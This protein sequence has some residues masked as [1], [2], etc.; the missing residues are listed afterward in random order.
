MVDVDHFKGYNDRYGNLIGDVCLK[1]VAD[2]MLS[3]LRGDD[4]CIR[5]GGEEFLVI[6]SRLNLIAASQLAERLRRAILSR[7]IVNESARIGCISVSIGVSSGSPDT[8]DLS[9]LIAQADT[10]LYAAK[11]NGRNQIFPPLV[12]SG[13]TATSP[14][15][16]YQ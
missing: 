5:F 10:A 1:Q 16:A 6:L 8:L 9:H 2:V 3:E 15:T 13:S 4:V 12:S 14:R 7:N 11:E